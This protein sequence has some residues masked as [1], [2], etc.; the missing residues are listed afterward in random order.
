M[1]NDNIAMFEETLAISRQGFYTKNG[2][3]ICLTLS[4]K[5]RE[6]AIPL[7][8]EALR[9]LVE[10]GET[11]NIPRAPGRCGVGVAN[12]DSF[13]A[14]A[15]ILGPYEQAKKILVLNFA[16]PVCPGG[17][18]ER[19]ARAQEEDLCRRSTLYLSLRSETA[20]AMYEYNRKLDDH[21][22]SDYML[23]SPKVEILRD[24]GG[25]PLDGTMV[26]GV[27]TAAAPVALRRG[28]PA[29]KEETNQILRRRIRGILHVAAAYGYQYLVLGAWGCG[30]FGNDAADVSRLFYE[31]MKG[32]SRSGHTLKDYFTRIVFA[33]LDRSA[34]QYNYECF[35]KRFEDFC[36]G[37]RDA[38]RRG[39]EQRKRDA[40]VWLDV[41]RGCLTGGA[42]GDAL[43]YPVEFYSRS[44]IL[45]HYGSNGIEA[46][47]LGPEGLARISDDTQMTLFTAAG[48]LYGTTRGS[49]R[50][51]MGPVARYVWDAYSDWYRM[52]NGKTP[53]MD[54]RRSWLADIP[55]LGARRAPG[56]TCMSALGRK[57]PGSPD[58]PLN[59]SKGCG[60]VMRVAPAALHFNRGTDGPDRIDLVREEAAEIAAL[61]HGHPLGWMP[62]AALAHIINRIAFRKM[63]IEE[64]VRDAI[65]RIR[66]SGPETAE[67]TELLAIMEKALTLSKNGG[68]DEE[69]I[70]RLGEGWV[71][72]ET[73]AIAIYCSVRYA[74]D[75]SKALRAAVNHSGDS[76][77]TGAVTG[78]IMGAA[79][80]YHRIPDAWKRDLECRDVIL[81]IAEDLCRGCPVSE[82]GECG[83]PAW[84]A[85]YV[86]CRRPAQAGA[87]GRKRP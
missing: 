43:G 45:D 76:D 26:V 52:Q 38:A 14:A 19:G 30:V 62:A 69:N 10:S 87:E 16:N 12:Q 29:A 53:D 3:R 32:F 82:D 1:R 9:R 63:E 83:D 21:R 85:K 11:Q 51:I 55:E 70:P 27:L 25:E 77:S 33:V 8:P 34:S 35:A 44:E 75:F 54:K 15:S 71:A 31:E 72:E 40:E 65:A 24:T 18:V 23:L 48:I 81:E 49:L 37:E 57:R 60:G 36:A 7:S 74:D 42:A 59:N 78:N 80:G 58:S 61:T 22:A 5:E 17:G 68:P 2:K 47:D 84:T 13:A 46:Y 56:V 28:T 64:A 39:G 73:L 41:I 50:G 20:R 79:W 4:A 86:E 6:E 66:E 67:R